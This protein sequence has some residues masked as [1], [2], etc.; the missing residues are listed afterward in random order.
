M[1]KSKKKPVYRVMD[2]VGRVLIPRE[3]RDSADMSYGDIIR[4]DVQ[5]GAVTAKKVDIIDIDDQS[6]AA[7]DAYVFAAVKSMDQEIR[8]SLA[9]RLMELLEKEE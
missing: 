2:R 8:L 9:A 4:I 3:L 1:N 6:P 5:K 7:R